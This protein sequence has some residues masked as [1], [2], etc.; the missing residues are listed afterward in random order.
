MQQYETHPDSAASSAPAAREHIEL[1]VEDGDED[2]T[3]DDDAM[4]TDR[5][6]LLVNAKALDLGA[7]LAS[8]PSAH[9]SA[10]AGSITAPSLMLV[11]YPRRWPV[12][13]YIHALTLAGFQLSVL[14]LWAQR[15]KWHT[16]SP[17]KARVLTACMPAA[18]ISMPRAWHRQWRIASRACCC[19]YQMWR[20]PYL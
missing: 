5:E 18:Y 20:P 15:A 13:F 4:T 10:G 16:A 8:L 3:L 19:R 9:A 2:Q 1:D 17:W 14:A 12:T 11:A 6:R 7:L